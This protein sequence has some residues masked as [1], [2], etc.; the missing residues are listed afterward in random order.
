[1]TRAAVLPPRRDSFDEWE[2]TCSETKPCQEICSR[3]VD[4]KQNQT[5]YTDCFADCYTQLNHPSCT[6]EKFL[7]PPGQPRNYFLLSQGL[8]SKCQQ[9]EN[10][11]P[12]VGGGG[13]LLNR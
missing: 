3:N 12:Q 13:V 1:M 9:C 8:F 2:V 6:N 4:V 5:A 11:K 10:L 7:Y